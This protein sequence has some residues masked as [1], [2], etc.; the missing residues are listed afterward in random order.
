MSETDIAINAILSHSPKEPQWENK[1]E[2]TIFLFTP[3]TRTTA[4]KDAYAQCRP[5]PALHLLDEFRP[6]GASGAKVRV[7]NTVKLLLTQTQLYSNPNHYYEDLEAANFTKTPSFAERDDAMRAHILKPENKESREFTSS[8]TLN[9][10]SID[11]LG[12]HDEPQ[13]EQT[14]YVY[15]YDRVDQRTF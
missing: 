7:I 9:R 5:K 6:N 11:N 12:I 8:R 13:T 4:V 14:Q 2:R 10:V 3:K 1:P 15:M